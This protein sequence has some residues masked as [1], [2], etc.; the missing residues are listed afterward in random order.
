M[1]PP[2]QGLSK[3]TVSGRPGIETSERRRRRCSRS[4][5]RSKGSYYATDIHAAVF[6]SSG[7]SGSRVMAHMT[8]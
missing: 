5:K 2:K 1:R 7:R 3:D 4:S 6:A 8:R